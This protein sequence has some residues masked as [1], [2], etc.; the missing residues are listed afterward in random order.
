MSRV[1]LR[2]ELPIENNTDSIK[3]LIFTYGGTDGTD[4]QVI[5]VAVYISA[6]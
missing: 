1:C 6:Q 2:F 5:S 4:G 3:S